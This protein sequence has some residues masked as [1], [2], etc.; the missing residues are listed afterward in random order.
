[1]L[2]FFGKQGSKKSVVVSESCIICAIKTSLHE[3]CIKTVIEFLLVCIVYPELSCVNSGM[4]ILLIKKEWMNEIIRPRS[5]YKYKF[6][7]RGL[8]PN[9]FVISRYHPQSIDDLVPDVECDR[10]DLF[11]R[12]RTGNRLPLSA[13]LHCDGRPL[14]R[15]SL[16]ANRNYITSPIIHTPRPRFMQ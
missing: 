14:P 15:Y 13:T 7:R 16:P 10:S 6:R 3:H 11:R 9:H 2:V 4:S 1:M 12:K 5:T 8:F